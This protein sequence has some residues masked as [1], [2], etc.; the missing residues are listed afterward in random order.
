MAYPFNQESWIWYTCA[1]MMIGARLV[2]RTILFRS[3]KGLQYDDWIMVQSNL[4]PSDF[5]WSALT[6]DEMIRRRYGSKLVIVVEQMQIAVI[7]A[8]KV[9]LLIMYHRLT[10]TALR[11]ENVAIKLLSGYVALGFI[12]IEILYF[13]AWCRP[14]SEYYAVPTASSQCNALVHHRITKAVF[15]IS[16]DL[17]MLCIALQMLIRSLLPLKR[18]LIL[19]GIF[20]LGIFVVTASILNSYY[21]FRNPYEQTW[22]FWYVRESST[23]ILVANLPFTW[24]L[25]RKFFELGDFDEN[26]PPPWTYHSSRTAGGRKTAQLMHQ[27]GNTATV[28]SAGKRR[29]PNISYGSQGDRS[30]TLVD[31]RS[32]LKEHGKSLGNTPQGSEKEK[33]LLDEA[34]TPHDFAPVPALSAN[35]GVT[36]IDLEHGLTDFSGHLQPVSPD[37]DLQRDHVTASQPKI[38]EDGTGGFYINNRPISP[39]SRAQLAASSN[40]SREPSIASIDRRPRSPTPSHSGS[41]IENSDRGSAPGTDSMA[42]GTTG[43][44]RSARDGRARARLSQDMH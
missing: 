24:T 23:A 22:I 8:C 2:S 30:M 39:P 14:F 33:D 1:V 28:S 35:D 19:C 36:N 25:L 17:I 31:S 26:S 42:V 40:R 27:S 7:W 9:C 21:S 6:A 4:V 12:V 11:N 44:G 32:P 3:I 5:D 38:T 20:S 34:I 29:S 16:S 18:K 15:N 13:A 37:H 41:T 43:G 10:R